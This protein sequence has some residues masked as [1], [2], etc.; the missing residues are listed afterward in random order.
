MAAILPLTI[1]NDYVWIWIPVKFIDKDPIRQAITWN[2]VDE[3]LW[4]QMVS[5][6]QKCWKN[7]SSVA[8]FWQTILFV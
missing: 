5:L 8:K 6:G 1:W 4:H 2:N 7:G 3:I